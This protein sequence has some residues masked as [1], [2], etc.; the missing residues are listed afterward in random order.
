MKQKLLKMV[1]LRNKKLSQKQF[2]KIRSLRFL[3]KKIHLP[4]SI[5]SRQKPL[6]FYF[7]LRFYLFFA[8]IPT[9]ALCQAK[10]VPAHCEEVKK[11]ITRPI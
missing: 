4:F 1:D 10:S 2:I 9:L 8:I 5:R 7:L 6:F 3:K 11:I